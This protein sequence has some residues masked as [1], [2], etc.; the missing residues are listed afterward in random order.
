[1]I[2]C[3][4]CGLIVEENGE[5][6]LKADSIEHLTTV[7]EVLAQVMVLAGCCWRILR[8]CKQAINKKNKK[9]KAAPNK[10]MVSQSHSFLF[11]VTKSYIC[12]M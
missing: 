12:I 11:S 5:K 9:K 2:S 1:M 6:H 3:E 4:Q 8:P 7:T 10:D